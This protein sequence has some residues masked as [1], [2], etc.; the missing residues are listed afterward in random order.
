MEIMDAR[1]VGS[2][3]VGGSGT[4]CLVAYIVIG[5]LILRA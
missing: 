3:H 4:P 1:D 2:K 5:Y